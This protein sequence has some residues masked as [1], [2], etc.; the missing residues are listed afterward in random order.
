MNPS[1]SGEFSFLTGSKT[2]I[3]G[4]VEGRVVR[5]RG[6]DC[7]GVVLRK[8]SGVEGACGF[9]HLRAV[10]NSEAVFGFYLA[11]YVNARSALF[12]R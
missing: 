10:E 6:Q 3:H 8:K 4:K 5:V 12:C 2:C 9:H 7:V 11:M 1:P